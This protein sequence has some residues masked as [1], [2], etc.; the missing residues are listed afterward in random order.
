MAPMRNHEHI[1]GLHGGCNHN[2]GELGDNYGNPEHMGDGNHQ[3]QE[4]RE[5]DNGNDRKSEDCALR[6]DR[7]FAP[8]DPNPLLGGR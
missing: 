1:A 3:N 2:H 6:L 8:Q 4:Y 7:S 5:H